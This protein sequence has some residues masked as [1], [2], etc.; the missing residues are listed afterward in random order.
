MHDTHSVHV[1][2]S[3]DYLLGYFSRI[4][5]FEDILLLDELH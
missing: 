5:F 2:D 1:V 3:L 4:A